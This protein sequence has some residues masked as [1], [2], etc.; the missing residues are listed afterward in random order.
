MRLHRRNVLLALL[1]AVL[2]GADLALAPE[3]PGSAGQ[4]QPL[5]PGLRAEDVRRVVVSAADGEQATLERR[6]ARWRVVELGGYPAHEEAVQDLI[7]RLG[8][9]RVDD[10]VARESSS[11][12][13]FGVAAEGRRL[14]LFD[15]QGGSLADLVVG[16]PASESRGGYVRRSGAGVVFRAPLLAPPGSAPEAWLDSRLFTVAGS[17]LESVRI[18]RAGEAALEFTRTPGSEWSGPGGPRAG[19][20]VVRLLRLCANLHLADVD[21]GEGAGERAWLRVELRP[22]TGRPEWVEFLGLDQHGAE[23]ARLERADEG[24]RVT[25]PTGSVRRLEGLLE[26]LRSD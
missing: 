10:P 21:E 25:V 16:R 1:V 17:E 3:A 12:P 2:V 19:G 23:R 15:A 6:R 24:F 4:V 20:N 9:V 18:E 26:A 22:L 13:R 14:Q 11:H 5:L 8:G 7:A